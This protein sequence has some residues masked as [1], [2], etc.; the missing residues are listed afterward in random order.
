MSAAQWRYGFN[1]VV[2]PRQILVSAA[3]SDAQDGFG[4]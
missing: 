2:H 1:P 3:K 4:A